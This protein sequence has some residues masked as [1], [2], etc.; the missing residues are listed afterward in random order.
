[1][2]KV[3]IIILLGKEV[4]NTLLKKCLDSVK[5]CDEII[6]VDTKNIKGNFADWRNEGLKRAKNDWILYIDTDEEV[7]L[8]LRDEIIQLI[9][10]PVSKAWPALLINQNNAYAIPRQNIIFGQEF[11]HGGQW[12]DYQ[13]RLFRKKAFN[14]WVG[15]LHEEPVYLGDLGYLKSSIIH[16]KNLELGQMVEKT[17]RWSEIEAKLMLDANHPRMNIIRFASAGFREFLLRFVK[18]LCFLDGSKGVI[19]GIYQ[20]YSRLISYSKLWEKQQSIIRT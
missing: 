6:K 10:K 1:M 15:D 19:Y 17:N 8:S 3:S 13:K 7:S 2:A 5:W 4:D 14:K 16:H 11:K 9:S 20:I 18:Q 12:P